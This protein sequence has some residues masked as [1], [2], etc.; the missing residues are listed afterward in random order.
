ML[1]QPLKKKPSAANSRAKASLDFACA[2]TLLLLLA[3]LLTTISLCILVSMGKPVFFRQLRT[4]L[5]GKRFYI[6]KFRTMVEV[7]P[8]AQPASEDR[9]LTI[10]GS[11][12]RLSSLDELPQI[13]NV[14]KGEMSLIGPRPQVVSFEQY[15]TEYQFRRHEVRPGITGWAQINGRNSIS[16]DRKF[17]LDVWY[18]DHWS[19]W[20]DLKIMVL[21]PFRLFSFQQ[22]VG[23][24]RY[25][26]RSFGQTHETVESRKATNIRPIAASDPG[27]TGR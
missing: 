23:P 10:L 11:F 25:S 4:G 13:F 17:E 2:L 12:L 6:L 9:R 27:K 15:Y 20:L 5:N 18:V 24:Y 3:P 8:A 21:T 1:L 14:L 16:W 26:D 22:V 19:L 7:G